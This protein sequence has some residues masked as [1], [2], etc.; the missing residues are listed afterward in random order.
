MKK[1]SISLVWDIDVKA[2]DMHKQRGA[3]KCHMRPLWAYMPWR[4]RGRRCGLPT[5]P[6]ISAESGLQGA[7]DGEYIV[8]AHIP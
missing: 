8:S 4:R 3:I 1:A 5:I 7:G 2:G 6:E